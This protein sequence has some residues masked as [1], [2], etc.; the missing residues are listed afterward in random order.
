MHCSSKGLEQ[1]AQNEAVVGPLRGFATPRKAF[2]E[3]TLRERGDGGLNLLQE[4]E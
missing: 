2:W 4:A 1:E 3:T